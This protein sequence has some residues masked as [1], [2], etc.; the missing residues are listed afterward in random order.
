MN[1]VPKSH[2]L[3]RTRPNI[4]HAHFRKSDYR[5]ARRAA[6]ETIE[7]NRIVRILD[8]PFGRIQTIKK[9]SFR[10]I[11]SS[12]LEL[13]TRD[14]RDGSPRGNLDEIHAFSS[15]PNSWPTNSTANKKFPV[16]L[17]QIV[18]ISSL[19]IEL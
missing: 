12:F 11:R 10:D 15:L 3:R 2:Y 6:I 4:F 1:R 9:L 19:S 18:R 13:K 5:R 7:S 17:S 8:S 14:F 16:I